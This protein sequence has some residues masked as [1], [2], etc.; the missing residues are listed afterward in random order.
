MAG[1]T[2]VFKIIYHF[3]FSGRKSSPDYIDYVSVPGG[4]YPSIKTCF[5]NNGLLRGSGTMVI[6][7]V[8]SV[9]P[10]SDAH[11]TSGGGHNIWQ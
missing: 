7:A 8:Q 6:D 5:S 4:D 3:E 10:G 2:N 9:G 11:V 1:T